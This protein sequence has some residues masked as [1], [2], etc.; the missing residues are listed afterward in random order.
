MRVLPTRWRQKPVGRDIWNEIMSQSPCVY[1][2]SLLCVRSQVV[3]ARHCVLYDLAERRSTA[4]LPPLQRPAV[5][6][7][8]QSR[9]EVHARLPVP[10]TRRMCVVVSSLY[11]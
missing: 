8:P 6:R 7:R 2:L 3:L 9:Q 10:D 11:M 5:R 1:T 4:D